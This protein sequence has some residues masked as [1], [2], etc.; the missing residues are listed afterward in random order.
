M[1]NLSGSSSITATLNLVNNG[2]PSYA[3]FVSPAFS[4]L[5]GNVAE[6]I[7]SLAAGANTI[8]VPVG[9]LNGVIIVMPTTAGSGTPAI[10]F[11]VKGVSGDTGIP[12]GLGTFQVLLFN[13][14][15]IP[16]TFVIT[17]NYTSAVSVTLYFF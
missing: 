9:T 3:G 4:F 15:T 6:Q 7:I 1:P 14:A 12:S 2:N 13:G 10:P 16:A 5:T 11:S 17:N 8:T